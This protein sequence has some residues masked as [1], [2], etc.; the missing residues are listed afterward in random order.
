MRWGGI[1]PKMKTPRGEEWKLRGGGSMMLIP[2]W[3]IQYERILD[4]CI[5]SW[6]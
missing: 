3:F 5:N 1:T 4:E 2:M 6:S